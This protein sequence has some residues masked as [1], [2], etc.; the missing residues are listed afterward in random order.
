MDAMMKNRTDFQA[1][2]AKF[3]EH[4]VRKNKPNGNLKVAESEGSWAPEATALYDSQTELNITKSDN[5]E[6]VSPHNA[7]IQQSSAKPPAS[8]L[9]LAKP[10]VVSKPV[11]LNLFEWM[12]PNV[13]MDSRGRPEDLTNSNRASGD[14]QASGFKTFEDNQGTNRD[15]KLAF[16]ERISIWENSSC[17]GIEADTPSQKL[18]C[19]ALP[20]SLVNLRSK[21]LPETPYKVTYLSRGNRIMGP[22]EQISGVRNGKALQIE[23]PASVIH[24]CEDSQVA[25]N[26]KLTVPF[27]E[28]EVDLSTPRNEQR[29]LKQDNV[30]KSGSWDLLRLDN[31]GRSKLIDDKRGQNVMGSEHLHKSIQIRELPSLEVLGPPPGKPPRP[32]TMDLSILE[33]IK[34]DSCCS[35]ESSRNNDISASPKTQPGKEDR[36]STES[37]VQEGDNEKMRHHQEIELEKKLENQ[38]TKDKELNQVKGYENKNLRELQKK[39]NLTGSEVPM[40]KVQIQEYLKG[41]KLNLK[42]KPGEVVEIIRMIDCPAGK[43]LAKTQDGNYGYIQI[44]AVKMNNAEMKEISNRMSKSLQMV[45]EIYDDVDLPDMTTEH[46]IKMFNSIEREPCHETTDTKNEREKSRYSANTIDLLAKILHIGK[47]K[48]KKGHESSPSQQSECGLA[49]NAYDDV[50]SEA[51]TSIDRRSQI[52]S[53][54][55]E[56]LHEEMYDDVEPVRSDTIKRD[57]IKELETLSKKEIGDGG[58]EKKIKKINKSL[59]HLSV[60]SGSGSTLSL[61]TVDSDENSVYEDIPNVKE[62]SDSE[63]KSSKSD[64]TKRNWG[65]VFRKRGENAKKTGEMKLEEGKREK[66]KGIF[67]IKRKDL[68]AEKESKLNEMKMLNEQEFRENFNYTKE[69]VV[70]NVAVVEQNVVQGQEGS[71]YLPVKSGEKLEVIDIGEDNLIICRNADGKYGYVHVRYLTFG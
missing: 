10:R 67:K 49:S 57:Q 4:D 38:A 37:N 55:N 63:S 70:E 12:E 44:G 59:D 5:I 3:Q 47:E 25:T 68:S 22:G 1:L 50:I 19:S 52:H 60:N 2:Q 53:A 62:L 23:E 64:T 31:C 43:W 16:K 35:W 24:S 40:Y 54:D 45:E 29:G 26:S 17:S 51:M 11:H 18:K 6:T 8:S 34:M 36:L 33:N 58:N 13:A 27:Y 69:I 14:I 61:T 46:S 71:L 28:L 56:A 48:T 66:V 32:F 65:K 15:S 9:P 42:V 21:A 30:L 39:F 41:G 20:P 7:A